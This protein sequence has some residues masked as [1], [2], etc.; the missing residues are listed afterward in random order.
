M[1]R[2]KL[3]AREILPFISFASGSSGAGNSSTST[4]E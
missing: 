2:A 3:R 1:S 4:M